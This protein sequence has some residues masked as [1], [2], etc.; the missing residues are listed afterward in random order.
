MAQLMLLI[1]VGMA[2]AVAEEVLAV[3]AAAVY[4]AQPDRADPVRLR[5]LCARGARGGGGYIPS[6]GTA[7]DK[8]KAGGASWGH[9]AAPG[10]FTMSHEQKE[11]ATAVSKQLFLPLNQA[12]H[13]C[14][15]HGC[16]NVDLTEKDA[17]AYRE[18]AYKFKPPDGHPCE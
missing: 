8:I 14:A 11:K 6:G 3:D 7:G 18:F 9:F 5:S 4:S 15:I 2:D 1:L 13:Q 16:P 12:H 10:T 17:L